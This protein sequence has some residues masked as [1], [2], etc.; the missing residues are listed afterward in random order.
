MRDLL[1]TKANQPSKPP[2][3]TRGS[4]TSRA[5]PVTLSYTDTIHTNAQMNLYVESLKAKNAAKPPPSHEGNVLYKAV[6]SA[7]PILDLAKLQLKKYMKGEASL[8]IP[9]FKS[10]KKKNK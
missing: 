2:T 8:D 3:S 5:R 10:N 9:M 1:Q 4:K 6:T 7:H